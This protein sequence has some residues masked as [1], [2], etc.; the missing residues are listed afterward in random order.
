MTKDKL[1]LSTID[2][3][4]QDTAKQYGLGL[5]IAEYCT[6]WNM[7]EKFPETDRLVQA[8]LVGISNCVFH[9]PFNELFPCAIDPKARALAADRY[10]QAIK[11]AK[12]Y[13]ATKVIIHGGY[14][15]RIYYPVWYVE[16]SVLF[17]KEFLKEDPSVEIVLENV[18]EDDPQ[19]L[20]D[21]VKGVDNPK[22]RLCL[23][24]GH[25]NAY[26]GILV[27]DWLKVWAPYLSHFHLHNND[28]T[29]DSH[30]TLNH[31]SIPVDIFVQQAETLCP[32][33]TFTLEVMESE[34]SVRWLLEE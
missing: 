30:S 20:L 29:Q 14:N 22:L 26:S 19:W 8:K 10:R 32:D 7:D 25:V 2:P 6:A 13:G 1:Y 24:V 5:E 31:G 17:W 21:I 3:N 33:A 27:M 18:L 12:V 4:A 28:G 23:D 11:L 9:A 16:Q 34:P 15:P